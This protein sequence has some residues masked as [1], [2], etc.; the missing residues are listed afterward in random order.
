MHNI[1]NQVV[2]LTNMPTPY[3][4]P[5]FECLSKKVDEL[6][7]V[8][9]VEKESNRKWE[10]DIN[11]ESVNYLQL[12]NR[13]IRYKNKHIHYSFDL[14]KIVKMYKDATFI[15][16]DA[17]YNSYFMAAI[18]KLLGKRYILWTG[19]TPISFQQSKIGSFLKERLVKNAD[20]ILSYGTHTTEVIK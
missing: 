17:S 12:K 19:W 3:R 7:V 20:V 8:Y 11:S 5:L 18:L 1:S 9:C 10:V 15:I 6:V 14:L 2:L 4:T 13:T 16:G